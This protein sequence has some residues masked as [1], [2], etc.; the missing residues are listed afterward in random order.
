MKWELHH[1]KAS[2][3]QVK[4]DVIMALRHFKIAQKK[5][6]KECGQ[7]NSNNATL[8]YEIAKLV[9]DPESSLIYLNNC[10]IIYKLIGTEKDIKNATFL[11]IRKLIQLNQFDDAYAIIFSMSKNLTDQQEI[12]AQVLFLYHIAK[13]NHEFLINRDQKKLL[14]A[15]AKVDCNQKQLDAI[16]CQFIKMNE[17]WIIEQQ[18]IVNK[19]LI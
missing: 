12:F 7:M 17:F 8:L 6:E 13:A 14:E 19:L 11:K 18:K 3:Y 2:V 1:Q 16:L 15:Y 10:C 9:P 5:C 4:K